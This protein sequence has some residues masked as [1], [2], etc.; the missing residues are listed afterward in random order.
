MIGTAQ[1]TKQTTILWVFVALL[2]IPGFCE[3]R[4]ISVQMSAPTIA[5][6]GYSWPGVGQY[7]KITGV[8]YA[9]VDPADRRNAIIVDIGLAERQ[10]APGQPGKTRRGK[11]AY[12]L[13]F[14]ILKPANLNGVDRSLNGYGK[15]M[16]EPPN[17]GGKTWTALGRVTGGGDD[18]ATITDPT[19]LANSFLMPRGYT[20]VWSGWEPLV[21]LANLGTD[22]TASVALPIA[23]NRGGSTITGPAYEYIV[24]GNSTTTSSTLSY[25]PFDMADKTTAVL[26]HRVHLDDPPVPI[27]STGWEYTTTVDGEP[28]IRLLPMG[29]TFVANDI[30]EFSYTAKDPTVAGLGFAAIRDWVSWL[31]YEAQDHNGTRNPLANYITRIYTEISSQP[32]RMFNDFRTLGFNEDDRGKI[33]RKVFDGHMQWISAGS[34]IGMNYRFSQSGRTERNRQNHLYGENLFPFANVRTTDPFT[35]ITASRYDACQL[36]NT[37]AFGVEI[38][39]ANEYWVKTASLLHTQ[40]D[41]SADLPDSAFNRNYFMSSMQHG[42]GNATNRGVCQQFGNPLNSAPVQRALFLALDAWADDGTPPPA[43]RVPRLDDGTLV[44]PADTGFPT[45]IPDPFGE[46]PT[47]KVTYTGLK[48]SRYRF[49][50]GPGF[51]DASNP[52]TFGIPTIFPPVIAPPLMPLM[53]DA[54]VPIMSV[55]GPVYPSF[56]PKTDRDGNDIAGVRLPDVTVPLATY[57]GWGLRRGAQANDGCESTGQYIPFAKTTADRQSSG[58]PRRSIEERYASFDNYYNRVRRA[59]DNMV[60]DRLLL[61]EDA[62]S[63][64]QRLVTAGLTAGVP[65]PDGNMPVLES[66]FCHKSSKPKGG[67]K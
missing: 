55:N 33:G 62:D 13:N 54:A 45:N 50:F 15:V 10:A 47:G 8:A 5:F 51:Y 2:L 48:T 28:A 58:D 38:Y 56:V 52:A 67:K 11:V 29:T 37:C 24:V 57:T 46:T 1:F 43:S 20:L 18:P 64:I 3:A 23:K 9:E 27:P 26:T 61:C 22:L 42:T 14:Y 40:P 41:G 60:K 6:G 4:V 63:Q 49:D 65:A 30:Y 59:V 34:G 36:T 25:P 19:I 44:L 31:R 21:D 12:L 7:E 39:S 17:R 35:G 32:G 53:T 66:E 16:Y